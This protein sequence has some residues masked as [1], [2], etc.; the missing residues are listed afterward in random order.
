MNLRM[1]KV[2]YAGWKQGCSALSRWITVVKTRAYEFRFGV[3]VRR[4]NADMRRTIQNHGHRV[5]SLIRESHPG[6]Y[7]ILIPAR[8]AQLYIGECLSSLLNQKIPGGLELEVLVGIDGC[9]KT[10][11]TLA[12]YIAELPADQ[13]RKVRSFY[14]DGHYGP[15]IIRN[16]LLW[17]SRGEQVQFVDADDVIVPDML[18]PLC[19]FALSCRACTPAYILRPVGIT[20]DEHLVPI[21]KHKPFQMV[22]QLGLSKAALK[23]LGGFAPWRCKGDTDFL[24]RASALGVPV[25]SWPQIA[26]LHRRHGTQ[27]I[28]GPLTGMK[29][30]L[31]AYYNGLIDMRIARGN[32]HEVPVMLHHPDLEVIEPLPDT[33]AVP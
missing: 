31:R 4:Q 16:T 20:T 23:L 15:Y 1:A 21:E 3:S 26:Y 2:C 9:E 14:F 27:L 6:I 28:Q 8:A 30:N 19:S 7:S 24:R 18:L 32:L 10:R 5:H 25:Y 11:D 13:A 29:S 12:Q 22:G 17:A 33:P